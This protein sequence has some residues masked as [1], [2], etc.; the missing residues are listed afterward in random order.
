GRADDQVKIRGY[1]VEPGEVEAALA[2]DPEVAAAVVVAIAEG[3]GAVLRAYA[4]GTRPGLDPA[5]VRDRQRRVLP[6]YAVPADVLILP[7]LPLTANGNLD[8]AALPRP[9][10]RPAAGPD[11]LT[12]DTERLV[13]GVWRAVLG[14]PRI[15]ATDNFF[16]IGGHSLA[17]A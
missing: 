8:R 2:A 6:E 15:G 3:A 10:A 5:A 11:G 13:A 4:V 1:R 17:I 16:D 12:G 9:Q 14:L 7:V